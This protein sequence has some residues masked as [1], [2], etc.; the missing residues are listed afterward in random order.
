MIDFNN[1]FLPSSAP[2]NIKVPLP[3][4]GGSHKMVY[5]KGVLT[6][7]DDVWKITIGTKEF[8]LTPASFDTYGHI[9]CWSKD[10]DE[11]NNHIRVIRAERERYFTM[12]NFYPF[13]HGHTVYGRYTKIAGI[14]YFDVLVN[15][16]A[17]G[18]NGME[19]LTFGIGPMYRDMMRMRN[20][21][22]ELS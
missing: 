19:N 6:C 11:H 15:H 8:P 10:L 20:K 2:L 22:K 7:T 13:K 14:I 12:P 1:M 17:L 9:N 5:P 21:Q 3:A 18:D 16:M 4:S